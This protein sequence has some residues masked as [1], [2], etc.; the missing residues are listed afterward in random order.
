MGYVA[1]DKITTTEYNDIFLNS[2]GGADGHGINHIMG[3]GQL[4]HGLGQTALNSV[5]T[6]QEITATQWN[7]LFTA[8]DNVA[9]HTNDTLTSTAQRSTGDLIEIKSALIADLAT[10]ATSVQNG[11]TNA[12]ALTTSAAQQTSA[13]SGRYTGSHIV[14]HSTTFSS[15][16]QMRWFFN[17]GGKI[18][19]NVTRT[20]NGGT[21]ATSKDS[22]VDELITGMGDLKIGSQLSTRS[23]STETLTTNGFSIGFYD[24]TTSYQTIMELTQNSGTY[25]TMYFRVEAKVDAAPGSSTVLTTKV[26]IVDPDSGDSEFTAGNTASIDQYANFIGVTNVI[27]KYV[28]ATTSEGLATIYEPFT[29]AVVS[30][31]TV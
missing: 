27:L 9:N 26:S 15:A 25:T 4:Y 17:Q 19:L 31:N 8:M 13:A 23:G 24:L 5:S 12:S 11:C 18:Q 2:T 6:A 10:L 14:E 29:T 28:K 1:G 3:T 20:G 30:N 7:S 22:S 21:T 16:N